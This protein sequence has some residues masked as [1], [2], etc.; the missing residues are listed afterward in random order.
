M[1]EGMHQGRGRDDTCT[2]GLSR[3]SLRVH[4][5]SYDLSWKVKEMIQENEKK[6]IMMTTLPA[7]PS[8]YEFPN[9]PMFSNMR[10]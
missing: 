4:E 10:E 2:H 1:R 3:R 7:P 9:L 6:R 5:F 8:A